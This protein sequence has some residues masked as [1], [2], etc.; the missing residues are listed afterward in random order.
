MGLQTFSFL[1]VANTRK[2]I[3]N[4]NINY[5]FTDSY[6]TDKVVKELAVESADLWFSAF[7]IAQKEGIFADACNYSN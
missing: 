1:S 6:R 3:Y 7:F 5:F 2:R 4:N